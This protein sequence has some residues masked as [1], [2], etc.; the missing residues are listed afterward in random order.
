[1]I[2]TVLALGHNNCGLRVSELSIQ[3]ATCWRLL[4]EQE[5]QLLLRDRATRK[6]AKDS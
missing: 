5:A 2:R 3:T 1:M 6:H 4:Y